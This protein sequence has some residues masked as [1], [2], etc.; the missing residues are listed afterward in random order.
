MRIL[1]QGPRVVRIQQVLDALYPTPPVP[2][3]SNC[4][5]TFLVAVVL[6]A[7]TTDGKVNEVT[8][9]L[10]R[11]APTAL[12]LSR[13]DPS[14]VEEIIRTVGLAPK[15][16]VYLVSLSKKI[17]D[18][19]G[20]EVPNSFDELESLP[21]VGHKTASVVMS[22]SFGVPAFPVD[23]HIQ[24]LAQRWGLSTSSNVDKIQKDLMNLFPQEHWNKV[25]WEV[26]R[27]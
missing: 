22:Q 5:F 18:K 13:M 15:K 12:D 7:Q 2:L 8:K 17:V 24:R 1:S 23:T 3:N 14:E 16:A 26:T 6:S 4:T 21:G 9:E 25:C 20:G 27:K 11:R 10:F 19:F